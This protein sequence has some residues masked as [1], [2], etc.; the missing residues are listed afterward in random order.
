MH[1]QG[2]IA[3]GVKSAVAAVA[4]VVLLVACS[5]EPPL[6]FGPQLASVRGESEPGTINSMRLNVSKG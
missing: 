1:I 2:L 3:M 5:P 6:Y 4:G